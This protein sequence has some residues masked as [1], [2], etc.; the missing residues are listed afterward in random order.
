MKILGIIAEYN[1]FHQGH[2]Y[3]LSTAKKITQADHTIAIMSGNFL[4]RGEPALINKWVRTE[5]AL[6][7]GIDLVIELPFVFA[8]QDANGFALGAVK[9]LDSLQI[10]D[11]LCFGCET[12]NRDILYPLGKFLQT[13]KPEYQELIKQ[14][15]KGGN[16]YPRV[17]AQALAEYHQNFGIENLNQYSPTKIRKILSYPN[18]IL[19]L[20]YLKHLLNL[21]SK[22]L[23]VPIKRKG[24]GY[25]QPTLSGEISS[26]TSIRKEITDNLVWPEYHLSTLG[27]KFAAAIPSF[28]YFLLEKEFKEGRNPITL[29]SYEQYIL[30]VLRKMGSEEISSINGVNEGLENRIK[31]A[32]L[33]TSTVEELIN[34]IKTRRYT[35]TKI[36]RILLHTMMGLTKGEVEDFN[37]HGP[38][39]S[40]VLGFSPKG[41]NLLRMAKENSSLPIITKLS[42]YVKLL[43]FSEKSEDKILLR[44]LNLDILSTDIYVLGYKEKKDRIGRLDFT[45]KIIQGNSFP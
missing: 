42:N 10:V 30:G 2:L 43:N 37:R 32:S 1:P 13:E 26:A 33:K 23:P 31:K 38:L 8:T 14:K 35:R 34:S 28:S 20:E 21:N 44:M 18:N 41:K 6:K 5:M 19:A 9:L 17:R 15:S 12:P 36:Q 24:A 27:S 3:H 40:R 39:Y 45:H 7:A 11:Y 25:H 22:I 29:S 16:E 4:Q